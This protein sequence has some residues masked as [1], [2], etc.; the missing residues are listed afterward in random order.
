[1]D[2]EG[3]AWVTNSGGLAGMNQSSVAKF[4]INA[5]GFAEM[6]FQHDVG[7]T[8]KVIDV[9]SLGNAWLASQGDNTI[10]AFDTDGNRIGQF[11]GGGIDGPWGLTV[12]SEDNIWVANFGPLNFNSIHTRG[13][14]SK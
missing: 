6:V 8:L 7:H 11:S 13:G 5:E 12:D 14:I 1:I 3:A 4:V 10:Y 9:D 2:A